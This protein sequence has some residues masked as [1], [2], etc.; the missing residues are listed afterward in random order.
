MVDAKILQHVADLAAL[1][2]D[3]AEHVLQELNEAVHHAESLSA[4]NTDGVA[5]Y[6]GTLTKSGLFAH[7][8]VYEGL[9]QTEELTVAFTNEDDAFPCL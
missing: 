3:D 6:E 1:R 9:A 2:V 8:T 4:V 7:G 5:P